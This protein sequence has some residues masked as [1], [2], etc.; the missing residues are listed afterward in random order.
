M[1]R[2]AISD[3]LSDANFW[4]VDVAPIEN[5]AAPLFLPIAGF[6]SISAPEVTLEMFEINS[7]NSYWHKKIVKKAEVSTLTLQRGVRFYDSDFWNWTM[8]AL[9]GDT[10]TPALNFKMGAVSA[11]GGAAGGGFS[12]GGLGGPT[13]RRNLL[14]VHFFRNFPLPLG[15]IPS[16]AGRV[17]ASV[18]G[19]GVTAAVA[20]A[21]GGP[22]TSLLAAASFVD[23]VPKL[24]AR[25]WFLN[26]C[27]PTRYKAGS[28][29]DAASGQISLMELDV[30]VESMEEISLAI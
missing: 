20:G 22:Q 17:A 16:D 10:S 11:L 30:A 19:A 21:A 3:F 13:P 6:H 18:I 9:Y 28:D 1:A 14:L 7:A 8:T 12:F 29:F 15:P 23:A 24:P 25:A 5:I 26:G 27:L 4:L 2:N